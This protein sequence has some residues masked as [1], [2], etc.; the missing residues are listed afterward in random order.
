MSP[1]PRALSCFPLSASEDPDSPHYSDITEIYAKKQY[2]PV[3]YT[4]DDL[5]QHIE[6]DRTFEVL[7]VR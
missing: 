7:E 2:K 4:W 1:I 6:S 3:W 5:S